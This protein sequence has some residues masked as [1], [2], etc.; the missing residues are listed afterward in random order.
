MDGRYTAIGDEQC[1]ICVDGDVM[2]FEVIPPESEMEHI[3]DSWIHAAITTNQ[4]DPFCSSPTWQLAFH[5]A[6]SPTRRL[7]VESISGSLICFAEKVFT[8][9]D[10]YLTPL[11][12]SWFFGCP[13]LGMHSIELLVQAMDFIAKEYD[14]YFPKIMISGIRPK[15]LFARQ[16][17]KAVSKNFVI[18]LHSEG[19]QCAASLNDG[20]DGYLSHR[21]GNCRSKLQKARKRADGKGVYFERVLPLSPADALAVYSRM[22]AVEATSWKGIHACGMAESPSKEFYAAMIRRLSCGAHARVIMAK[23]GDKDIGFIFGGL[24]G[25]IYRGQQFSYD[26]E[27]KEFSLGNLMQFEQIQWLCE[28]GVIRYDMGPIVGQKMGYKAHWTEQRIPF[29]CWLLEKR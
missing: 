27:W 6:F 18:Y 12:P 23:Y 7:L 10:T 15:S 2:K 29:E 21:S 11:E 3:R 28:E 16:L 5:E 19:V 25:N 20:P 17:F 24:A 22:L 13:L 4:A 14:P 8:K 9:A 1:R 26:D